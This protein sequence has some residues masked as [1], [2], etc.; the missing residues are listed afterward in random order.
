M[1]V[2]LNAGS[3]AGEG[4]VKYHCRHADAP[5]PAC[6]GLAELDALRTK[7]FDAG[8]IGV[9]PDGVGFGN[10]SLRVG[11]KFV[12]TATATGGVRELGA[13]GYCQVEGWSIAENSLTCRGPLPASSEALT[14]AAVY[15]SGADAQCVVHVH[16]RS[17]FDGLIAV[18]AL[19]TP[20]EAAYGTPEMAKAVADIA[21]EHP[22]EGILAM[23]GHDEGV[24]AYG[25]SIPAVISLISF[26]IQNFSQP[27]HVCGK[28]CPHGAGH[29]S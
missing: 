21:R 6:A 1:T 19:S 8:L 12:V 27:E 11:D 5:A 14:H 23:R 29:V 15:E 4:Y 20:P 25:P 7:L 2:T 3:F 13:E 10:V 24:L 16:S 17:L 18:G 22:Q 9:R 28:N 26:A